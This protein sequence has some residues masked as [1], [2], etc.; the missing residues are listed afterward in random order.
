MNGAYLDKVHVGQFL[1]EAEASDE[2]HWTGRCAQLFYCHPCN[3]VF[4]NE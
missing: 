4:L 3:N 2:G 1:F